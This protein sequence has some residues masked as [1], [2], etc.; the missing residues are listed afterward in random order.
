MKKDIMVFIDNRG[1]PG[2]PLAWYTSHDTETPEGVTELSGTLSFW[3]QDAFLVS[4]IR[5][6]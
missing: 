4:T 1:F 2:G 5:L 6:F 3:M